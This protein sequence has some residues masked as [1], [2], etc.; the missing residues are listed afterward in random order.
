LEQ[1]EHISFIGQCRIIPVTHGI[2]V[3]EETF[4]EALS[5]HRAA[6]QQQQRSYDNYALSHGYNM[7]KG[8]VMPPLS[9]AEDDFTYKP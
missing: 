1:T 2:T 8:M 4:T 3:K 7:L 5:F 6:C 9:F